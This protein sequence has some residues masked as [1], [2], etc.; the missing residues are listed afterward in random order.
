MKVFKNHYSDLRRKRS[1]IDNTGLGE[2]YRN[3]LNQYKKNLN[4]GNYL[5]SFL[6][7]Q[8]LLE[9]R[10]Y[11]LYRM[12]L[13]HISRME[14]NNEIPVLEEIYKRNDVKDVVREIKKYNWMDDK[15]RDSLFNT[16]DIRNKHI[17]FSFMG[18]ENFTEDI[19]NGFYNQFRE[20][21]KLIRNYKK[22]LK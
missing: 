13:I 5:V 6:I 2:V 8:S 22:E 9:D 1:D 7:I 16:L 4:E 15:F 3:V 10:I 17:H 11:V 12:M 19:C 14:G 18:F 20:V 21:D